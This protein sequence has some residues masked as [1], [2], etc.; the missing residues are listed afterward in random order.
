VL[1]IPP[2]LKALQTRLSFARDFKLIGPDE[3]L[4]FKS[5]KTSRIYIENKESADEIN[6]LTVEICPK[7]IEDLAFHL[8]S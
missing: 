8:N 5:A 1:S 4:K 7:A 3:V 2:I 6:C